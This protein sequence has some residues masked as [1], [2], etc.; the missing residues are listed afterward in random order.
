MAMREC[1][2]LAR[3]KK[4]KMTRKTKDVKVFAALFA[5]SAPPEARSPCKQN[6]SINFNLTI[7][8]LP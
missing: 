4:T 3:E 1:F 5:K 8:Q 2:L 6:R 7:E